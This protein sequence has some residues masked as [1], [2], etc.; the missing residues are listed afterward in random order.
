MAE[1]AITP[2]DA[3]ALFNH[4]FPGFFEADYIKNLDPQKNHTE[5]LL[6]L[7]LFN[8]ENYFLD[9]PLDVSFQFYEGPLEDLQKAVAEVDEGWVKYYHEENLSKAFCAFQN[10]KVVSFCLVDD[11]GTHPFLGKEAKFGGP[12]CVGT[13]PEARR[14]G[15]GLMMVALATEILRQRG[16]DYSYIHYT[17][18]APWY[19]KIGYDTFLKW[20][21][22]GF[23][24]WWKINLHQPT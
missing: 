12:G 8:L 22:D 9:C 15:I 24:P 2:K 7:S 17:G 18:V 3:E 19:A 5:M 1:R 20:N 13:V 6:D 16:Y 14:Q 4:M 11:F 10:G 21:R 23:V